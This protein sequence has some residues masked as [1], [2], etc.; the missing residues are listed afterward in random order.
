[1]ASALRMASAIVGP[2][3]ALVTDGN[4]DAQLPFADRK[5]E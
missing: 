1:M 4:V 3:R 2:Y 5:S